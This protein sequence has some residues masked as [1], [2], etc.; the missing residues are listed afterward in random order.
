MI[1]LESG[2]CYMDATGANASQSNCNKVSDREIRVNLAA[3]LKCN[4]YLR[5]KTSVSY[6]NYFETNAITE[7]DSKSS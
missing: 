1:P 5:A 2:E 6:G 3:Y 7:A 4:F